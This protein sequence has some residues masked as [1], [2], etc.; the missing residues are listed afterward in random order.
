MCM[1]V[2]PN[3]ANLEGV[4]QL[5]NYLYALT[6]PNYEVLEIYDKIDREVDELETEIALAEENDNAEEELDEIK[7]DVRNLM[8]EADKC[9]YTPAQILD[10]LEQILF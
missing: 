5:H 8:R 10:A 3:K 9:D 6:E 1:L 4:K 2:R 7:Q